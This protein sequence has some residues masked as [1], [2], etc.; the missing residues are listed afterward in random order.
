MVARRQISILVGG[1]RLSVT[2]LPDAALRELP[3][4]ALVASMRRNTG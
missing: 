3:P 4:I 1:D 2:G